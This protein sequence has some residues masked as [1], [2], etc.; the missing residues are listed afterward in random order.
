MTQMAFVRLPEEMQLEKGIEVGPLTGK[1]VV[2]TG[3]S[4]GIGAEL[5]RQAVAAGAESV[6][7]TYNAGEERA[8]I[9]AREHEKVWNHKLILGDL[10]STAFFLDAIHDEEP[11][12]YFIANAGVELS[13][14]LEKHTPEEINR[15]IRTDLTGNLYLL[16]GLITKGIMARGGQ[17]AVVGS[18][19]ADGNHDQFA[20]SAAK[21]GLRGAVESLAKY[22][23]QV[24]EMGLGVKLLEPAF[25]RTP[26]TERI[27]K[28]LE[29]K[30]I[31]ARGGDALVEKFRS[32]G[33]VMD[34]DKA[35]LEI[36][37]LTYD[38]TVTGV[39][40]IPEGINLHRVREE[41]F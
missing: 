27:L 28:I 26:M 3:G 6:T 15:V 33:L 34:A 25:V 32:S 19:A 11:V 12:D 13:G 24:K 23:T 29:R 2:I 20:Y 10:E 8:N 16:R 1:S 9:I 41:Y 14:G 7:F 22:D 31:K 5:V 38:P 21:A 30:V 37:R 39:R 35:A 17:I 40:T 18:I 36:L 4:S